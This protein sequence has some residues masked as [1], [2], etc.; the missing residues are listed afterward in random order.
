MQVYYKGELVLVDGKYSV[1]GRPTKYFIIYQGQVLLV[2]ETE[3]TFI[4]YRKVG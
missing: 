3:L 2:K 4:N 1:I